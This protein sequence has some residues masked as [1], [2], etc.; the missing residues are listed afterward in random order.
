MLVSRVLC[1]GSATSLNSGICRLYTEAAHLTLLLC[2][3]LL[4]S[5]M[6]VS[7]STFLSTFLVL[8]PRYAPT[9][10]R[11]ISAANSRTTSVS[12]LALVRIVKTGK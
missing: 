7:S 10:H 11:W 6:P 4:I 9:T 8:F 1:M 12:S 3:S 2:I 5:A